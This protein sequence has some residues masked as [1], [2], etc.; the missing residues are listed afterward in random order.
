M[1]L[2]LTRQYKSPTYTISKLYINDVYFC[3]V[4]EDKDRDITQNT[5]ISEI[6]KIKVYGETAIPYGTYK[7]KI[8]YSSK[9]KRNL[10][11]IESVPG[12]EGVRIH[13]GNTEKDSAGCLI[14][15]ENKVKGKVIN[16]KQ[17]LEK[18]MNKLVGQ[19]DITIE[20]V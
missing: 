17:T 3:D 11:L 10:P 4:I 18:L 8:T 15:G 2:T 16:S 6:K 5:P 7:V 1:K 20:I 12:F 9:F 14:V 13:S 19:K